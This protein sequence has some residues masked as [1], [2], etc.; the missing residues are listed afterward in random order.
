MINADLL[1]AIDPED[2]EKAAKGDEEAIERIRDALIELQAEANGIDVSGLKEELAELEEGIVVDINADEMPL[3]YKLI[4]AKV[5]AGAG[6]AEIEALLS[7]F[8]IDADVS[9]FV[10]SMNEMAA[11]SAQA[12]SEVIANTSFSQDIETVAAETPVTKEAVGFTE[13]YTAIP[14]TRTSMILKDGAEEPVPVTETYYSW[15]KSISPNVESET[16]IN[17]EVGTSVTTTNGAGESGQ[18]KG[19]QIKN[20]HKSSGGKVGGSTKK[21]ASESVGSKLKKTSEARKKKSDIVDRYKEVN[22]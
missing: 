22:D 10:G 8:N 17:Q 19:V 11:A 13:S 3:L 9:D 2:F 15:S 4:E 12:G 6:A 14:E 20:A 7:G 1:S 16:G 5:A 21:S 18:V